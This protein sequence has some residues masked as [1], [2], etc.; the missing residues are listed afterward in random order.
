MAANVIL[1]FEEVFA[2]YGKETILHGL[3]FNVR[4]GTITTVIG[5]NGAG[6]STAFKVAFGMLPVRGGGYF[7][8][9]GTS[10]IFR[11]AS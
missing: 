3:S 7:S 11:R 1:R 10:R 4:Q 2:G 8:M 6:K 5:P 9:T